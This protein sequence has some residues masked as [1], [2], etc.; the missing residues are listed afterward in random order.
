MQKVS[1]EI[2]K[3]I[4]LPRPVNSR[5][6]D[7]GLLLVIGGGEFYTGSPALSA[8]AAFRA[9]VDMAQILAPK[10]AADIIASFSPNL[11]AFPLK[12]EWL[13][14]ENIAE[15]IAR[16]IS[17]KMVSNG[18]TATVI[19]GGVGRSAQTQQALLEFLEETEG[20]VVVDADAIHALAKNPLAVKD[21]SAIIT[22]NVYEFCVLTGQKVED[23]SQEEKIRIVQ[24]QAL[25]MNSVILLKGAVDVI[26]DGKE[27]VIDESGS[28][29]MSVGGTGDTL[30]GICGAFLAMGF[31]PFLSAM[32]GSFIN[33]KAG[34]LSAK[35]F[36][37]GMT[38]MDLIE[39]IPNV[40]K[41]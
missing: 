16:A 1:R 20:R 4:Y 19:G 14:K 34:E 6:Y 27:T 8:M 5:K 2:L 13:D 33:G 39:E 10:R 24:E 35:K 38:A 22:P 17:A 18:K 41:N 32:A 28:P 9:G 7:F 23:I 30:A 29:Y 37:P 25:K 12:G 40:I 3:Q 15:L 36:G 21:N 11:A 26:S 31:D